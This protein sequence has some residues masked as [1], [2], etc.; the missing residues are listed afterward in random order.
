MRVDWGK[1]WVSPRRNV[2]MDH[3]SA[4]NAGSDKAKMTSVL[5]PAAPAAIAQ[6][7]HAFKSSG[8]RLK[9]YASISPGSARKG[10]Q[11]VK[12]GEKKGERTQSEVQ[13]LC[14]AGIS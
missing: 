2:K 5:A 4:K 13:Q 3:R 1:Y 12:T 9:P 14:A 11:E 6:Q 7:K 10:S 8:R